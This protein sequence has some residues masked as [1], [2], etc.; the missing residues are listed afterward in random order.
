MYNRL[1]MAKQK[2]K[3]TKKYTG[4][5]AATTRPSVTKITAVNRSKPSQWLFERK[6]F[7]K[8]AGI[9][10]IVIL[11]IVLIVSGIISLVS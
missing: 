6:K 7:I 5:D 8:P 11:L 3:R 1:I 9:V 2:K 10:L 4:T